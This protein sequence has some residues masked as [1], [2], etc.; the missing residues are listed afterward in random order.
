MP[1]SYPSSAKAFTTKVD[2]AGNTIQAAHVNDLQ[3][4]VTAIEQDLI[5]GIPVARGGTGATSL[6]AN[7]VAHTNAGGTALTSTAGFTFDGTTLTAP[8]TTISATLTAQAL[9]D[10]SGAAAGQIK[11]PATQVPSTDANTLDDYEEGTW[12]PSFGGSGGQSGQAYTTQ[13]G[14]YTKIGKRVTCDFNIVL[15]TLGTITTDLQVQGLPFTSQNT[16]N[17]FWSVTIGKFAAL[18]S[19]VI[20][21]GGELAANA[22]VITIRRATAATQGPGNAAQADLSNTS[23]LIGSI[24]YMASA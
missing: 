10:V 4:E 16:A 13:V 8:A 20:W 14:T 17:A 5:A 11:F 6:S 7:R 19:T 21:L 15:S 9:V 18:T 24:T 1:A 3:L 23:Q 12:T 22:T 2:G